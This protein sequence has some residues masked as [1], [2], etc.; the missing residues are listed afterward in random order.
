[1]DIKQQ[2]EFLIKAYHECL[3]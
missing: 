3:Y 2:K 1:M